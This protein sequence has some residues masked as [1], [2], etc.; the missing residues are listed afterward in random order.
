[1]VV[2]VSSVYVHKWEEL[3]MQTTVDGER[4][5]DVTFTFT[6]TIRG[7]QSM[8]NS[9]FV[10]LCIRSTS[11]RCLMSRVTWR[12]RRGFSS[13]CLL[14]P[15]LL[16]LRKSFT[17][18]RLTQSRFDRSFTLSEFPCPVQKWTKYLTI[19]TKIEQVFYEQEEPISM[20]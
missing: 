13:T 4:D 15:C 2:L 5:R 17:P 19:H 16:I 18:K 1:M 8:I 11:S 9:E 10:F 6:W 20:L 14:H 12:R 3:K 7:L